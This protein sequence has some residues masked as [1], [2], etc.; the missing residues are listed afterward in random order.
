M[1][2]INED[3]NVTI[4]H[5]DV[6][7]GV[8]VG[9]LLDPDSKLYPDYMVEITRERVT[10]LELD[11][12]PTGEKVVVTFD[13]L[14]ADDL[15]LPNGDLSAVS[16]SAAY[17][18][19]NSFMDQDD[20]IEVTTILG[21]ILNLRALG[22]IAKERHQLDHSIVRVSFTNAGQY[23]PSVDADT[24]SLSVWDGSLTWAS[25]YWR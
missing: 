16:R 20:G 12:F 15:I 1:T 10:S 14:L 21:T 23:W 18:L 24:L 3:C 19:L 6:N 9:F 5:A 11:L 2:T 4:R 17:T 7:A 22:K 25:A 13:V 8:A